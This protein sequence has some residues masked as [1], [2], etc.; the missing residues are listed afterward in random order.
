MNL[1]NQPIYDI[2][3]LIEA[4][5]I[6]ETDYSRIA[7]KLNHIVASLK[8]GNN[9]QELEKLIN[10]TIG[11][12]ASLFL[13]NEH[14]RELLRVTFRTIIYQNSAGTIHPNIV[15][16]IFKNWLETR[17]SP[18]ERI[19]FVQANVFD[20]EEQEIN[21][22]IKNDFERVLSKDF[23]T[24]KYTNLVSDTFSYFDQFEIVKRNGNMNLLYKLPKTYAEMGKILGCNV[25]IFLLLWFNKHAK[26]KPKPIAKLKTTF[27]SRIKIILQHELMDPVILVQLVEKNETLFKKIEENQ[28]ETAIENVQD[29]IQ[30]LKTTALETADREFFADF[31]MEIGIHLNQDFTEQLKSFLYSANTNKYLIKKE[32]PW[33]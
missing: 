4:N 31:Y 26:R 22:K 18:R 12:E 11:E 19:L 14:F 6:T 28:L 21:L 9:Q 23:D 2:Y 32:L 10:D 15:E 1:N 24:E 5:I 33:E 16:D 7:D 25:D 29:A 13:K 27:N 17:L 8:N 3:Y 20:F 30:L